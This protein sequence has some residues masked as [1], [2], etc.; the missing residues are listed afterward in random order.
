MQVFLGT[1][2]KQILAWEPPQ[3]ELVSNVALSD[4]TGWVRALAQHSRWLYR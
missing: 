1:A 2:S 4:H 3:P